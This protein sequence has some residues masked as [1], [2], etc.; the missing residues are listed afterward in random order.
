M[1][2]FAIVFLINVHFGHSYWLPTMKDEVET[3]LEKV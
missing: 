3:L 1:L 2:I